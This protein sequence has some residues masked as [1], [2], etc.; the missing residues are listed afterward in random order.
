MVSVGPSLRCVRTVR[1]SD[2]VKRSQCIDLSVS[3]SRFGRL[4]P[5][6]RKRGGTWCDDDDIYL[7]T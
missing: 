5:Q 2:E 3:R 7:L 1:P 4:G 6:E